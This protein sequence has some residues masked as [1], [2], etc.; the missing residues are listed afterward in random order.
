M[1]GE[2]FQLPARCDDRDGASPSPPVPNADHGRGKIHKLGLT[3]AWI[4]AAAVSA[5]QLEPA[6]ERARELGRE[7]RYAEVVELLEPFTG[8]EDPEDRYIV[9][10]ELGRARFHLGDYAGADALLVEAVALRPQRVETALYLEATSY[11]TGNRERAYAI[12]REIVA[13][14]ATDLYL[15]VTLPGERR[16][17]ADPAVRAILDELHRVVEVDIETGGVFGIELG[18][19][20]E[21]VERRLG[22]PAAAPESALTAR[23]GPY[24]TSVYGF[25]EAGALAQIML[26]NEHLLRY[27]PFR[28]R[29]SG[30]LDWRSAPESATRALGAP[31]STAGAEGGIVVMVWEREAVRLTLEFAPPRPPAPTGLAADRPVLRVVRI[32][33]R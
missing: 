23:A 33:A 15:A 9:A 22:V 24:L 14:G 2:R 12:F 29:L 21:E 3:L 13:S 11:L 10:A 20:R 28:L 32:E 4:S 25:D 18:Q 6:V 30:D 26:H 31:V 19:P 8:V 16:F 27:T 1:I 7:H 5:Q 17:L